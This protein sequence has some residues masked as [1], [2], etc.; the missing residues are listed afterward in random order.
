MCG[1]F[2]AVGPPGAGPPLSE[3]EAIRLRDT[4][5]ARGPDGAGLFVRGPVVLAHRRL[6]I[7][8]PAAGQQPWVSDDGS[9]A[10]VFNGELYND[11]ELRSEL[12]RYGFRFRTRCD[13]ELIPAAYAVWG[14]ACVERFRGDFAFGL[15]DFARDRLLLARDRC[16]V[17]PL[18]FAPLGDTLVFASAVKAIRRHPAFVAT[19]NWAVLSH[20]LTTLRLTL[21]RETAFEGLYSLQPA[22]RLV[23]EN[24]SIT[25]D[26]YWE[27]PPPE[28]QDDFAAA[29]D[30]LE[31][32]LREAVR[33]RLAGDVPAGL[34]LSGGVDSNTLACL[35]RDE[36]GSGLPAGCGTGQ[37][38][39]AAPGDAEF[40]AVAARHSGCDLETVRLDAASY[41]E[42]WHELLDD[43]DTPVSTPTDA[44]LFRLSEAMRRRAGFVLGGEGAD[45]LLCGYAVPHFSGHDYD[46][47]L[48]LDGGRWSPAPHVARLFRDSLRRAYGRERFASPEE[49]Y[50]ALNSLIPSAAKPHLLR[51][52][53]WERTGRDEPMLG[54]YRDR[55]TEG[56]DRPTSERVLRLLHRVN[57]E[58]LLSRLDS[59]AMRA[60]L[61]VRPVYTDHLLVE[62]TFRLP[63]RFKIATAEEEPAPYLAASDLAS[64]GS[65]RDKRLLREVAVRLMP[66]KLARRPKASFPTPAATWLGREWS[67]WIRDILRTSPFA[68]AMLRPAAREELAA[69]PDRA[70][71]WLWPLLN[72]ALWGDRQFGGA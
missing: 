65:L 31:T 35:V 23:A 33:V 39:T 67:G 57:Q 56:E 54:W 29:T 10:V 27:P 36:T 69:Q 19:P 53:V 9:S 51:P 66:S 22:E 52:D 26:R 61:E 28:S 45:E 41:R 44:I 58:A 4:M 11:G 46:R 2:G 37:G 50:F 18:F 13:T 40:A 55:L 16:G 70:G 68:A 32:R 42:T 8:D 62:E 15:Y 1:I 47:A 34:F 17:K 24:G 49:H 20:Y 5:A 72:V 59:A 12:S 71:M 60:S 30:A 48:R 7:R 64:R 3:R 25:I 21:G 63:E 38:E 6:A 43:Y 14:N